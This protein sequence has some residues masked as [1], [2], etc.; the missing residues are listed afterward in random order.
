MNKSEFIEE[1]KKLNVNITDDMLE[2]LEIYKNFL[3]EYNSHTNLT[4]ITNDEDIYLKHFYDSLTIVKEVNLNEIENL[5]DIGT[6]AGFPG[7]VIKIFFPH[8][9]VTLLDSN[10]KKIKFLEELANKLNIEVE[11]IN[12]R[13]ENYA[14]TNLNKFDLVTSRAV[15]NLRVL[16]EISLP[17]VKTKGLFVAYKGSITSE[18][19]DAKDTITILHAK[20]LKIITFFLHNNTNERNLII[21]SKNGE[22]KLNDL[23]PYAKILKK[24]LQKKGK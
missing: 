1:V 8:I 9:R 12:S 4:A 16:A 22:T 17:L 13:V 2:K 5:L 15:A 6:G 21:I 10:N 23:R 3:Y 14:K 19:E 7:M 20:V 11:L 24:P 18:L